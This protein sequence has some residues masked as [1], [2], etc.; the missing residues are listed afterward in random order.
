MK[1]FTILRRVHKKMSSRN[2]RNFYNKHRILSLIVFVVGKSKNSSRNY[3]IIYE[4]LLSRLNNFKS[5]DR[6][7]ANVSG[8]EI[9]TRTSATAANDLLSIILKNFKGHR[10]F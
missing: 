9:I 6:A 10:I 2:V 1:M 3:A 5:S 4:V 8:E 7:N